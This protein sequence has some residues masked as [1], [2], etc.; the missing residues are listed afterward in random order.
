MAVKQRI[1][2]TR[3]DCVTTAAALAEVFEVRETS[4]FYP[5]RP[6][7][8]LGRIY[9]DAELSPP[10]ERARAQRTDRTSPLPNVTGGAR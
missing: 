2:G 4:D 7:S 10:P 8:L 3:K 9:L 1:T 6:P 5:N